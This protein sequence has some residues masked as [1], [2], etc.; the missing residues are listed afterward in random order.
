MTRSLFPVLLL[1]TA[2]GFP[3]GEGFADGDDSPEPPIVASDAPLLPLWERQKQVPEIHWAVDPDLAVEEARQRNVP[4]WVVVHD[5]ADPLIDLLCSGTYIEESFCDL[6]GRETVPIAILLPAEEGSGHQEQSFRRTVE[7]PVE[8][9]CPLL[10]SVRCQA[11][12]KA[13]EWLSRGSLAG[14]LTRR[15]SGYWLID[16]EGKILKNPNHLP[17]GISTTPFAKV[18]AASRET[19]GEKHASHLLWTFTNRRLEVAQ[20]L[21]DEREYQD[22]SK[23]LNVLLRDRQEF[24]AEMQLKIDALV[25]KFSQEARSLLERAEAMEVR[26]PHHARLLLGRIEKSFRGLP[27]AKEARERLLKLPRK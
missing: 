20:G 25:K 12:E 26:S 18:I 21:L 1:I 15:I 10:R 3:T 27:E 19:L 11:H 14:L 17:L 8:H 9:R 13:R 22:G 16:A 24:A 7:G 4:L 23:V 2:I 6:V 5:D